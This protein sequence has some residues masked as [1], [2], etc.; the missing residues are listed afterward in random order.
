MDSLTIGVALIT[1]NGIKYLPQQLESIATQTR[2]VHHIVISDDRS[3]DGTWAFLEAWAAQAPMRVTLIR[4]ETQLGLGRNFEQAIKAV[5]ADIIF[6]SDQ[7]DVW[8]PDRVAL[9][10]QVFDE[11]PDVLLVHTDAILV[12]AAGR[13]LGTTLLGELELSHA[14]RAAIHAGQAFTVYCRRN[15][16]TGATVA[17][18]RSLLRLALPFPTG[19]FHDAWLALLASAT[20]AVRLLELPTIHYRQH[21]N[22]LVGVKKRSAWLKLRHFLWQLKGPAQLRVMIDDNIASHTMLHERLRGC[23]DT[24]PAALA[25]SASSL[26]F[27]RARAALPGSALARLR[28]VLRSLAA[29]HYATF[30]YMPWTDAIRDIVR[31]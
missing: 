28:A 5:D 16:V 29:K 27:Y 25:F 17:I 20:G 12:D 26:A 22:N 7:D 21:G 19:T 24:A 10:T 9:L 11:A 18:R 2:P 4:N 3:T 6:T 31:K 1:Y 15:V 8:V 13:D 14:E 23:A 30:S